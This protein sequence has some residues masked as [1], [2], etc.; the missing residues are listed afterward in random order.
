MNSIPPLQLATSL[1]EQ[2]N[3]L[4]LEKEYI[5]RNVRAN[6]LSEQ[7]LRDR[8]VRVREITDSLGNLRER[9][10]MSPWRRNSVYPSVLLLLLFITVSMRAGS[11]AESGLIQ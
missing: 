1:E 10:A 7:A 5:E 3:M 2:I 4:D 9:K 11:E 6:G 8:E